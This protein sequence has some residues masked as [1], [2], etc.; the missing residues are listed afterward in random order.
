M[1]DPGYLKNTFKPM[2]SSNSENAF[3]AT[4]FKI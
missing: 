4:G 3:T 1:F 2:Y